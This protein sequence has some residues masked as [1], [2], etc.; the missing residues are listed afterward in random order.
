MI[1]CPD[2]NVPAIY[3][4]LVSAAW[5]VGHTLSQCMEALPVTPCNSLTLR[6]GVPSATGSWALPAA[7]PKADILQAQIFP[8]SKA[9]K[10][11]HASS[12]RE[13][14]SRGDCQLRGVV[15]TLQMPSQAA[16]TP[17]HPLSLS[18]APRGDRSVHSSL[19]PAT[20]PALR[21]E[22]SSARPPSVPAALRGPGRHQHLLEVVPDRD[23]VRT[24]VSEASRGVVG[25]L[26]DRG[27][28]V[29]G[30]ERPQ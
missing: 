1:L 18:Q 14:I 7:L 17:E 27:Q 29:N 16:H 6:R 12:S 4:C 10:G 2:D 26:G 15:H 21:L 13:S 30:A 28:G 20:P 23:P 8:N 22:P 11:F 19:Q 3:L 24:A 9:K 5:C 25:G